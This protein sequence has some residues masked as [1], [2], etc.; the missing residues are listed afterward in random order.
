MAII[1]LDAR[2]SAFLDL[3]AHVE[4]TICDSASKSSGYDLQEAGLFG[5]RTFTDTTCHPFTPPASPVMLDY[6][7][8]SGPWVRCIDGYIAALPEFGASIVHFS[9]AA[10]RYMLPY[11]VW[12]ECKRRLHLTYFSPINQD[13]AAVD[14][15]GRCKADQLVMAGQVGEALEAAS[16]FWP[17][18]PMPN[19]KVDAIRKDELVDFYDEVLFFKRATQPPPAS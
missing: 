3:I 16:F 9:T 19:L 4:G 2:L 17:K 1:K 10:G 13:L 6:I 5:I 11:K 14:L 15:I 18:L 12:A 8:A 7:P